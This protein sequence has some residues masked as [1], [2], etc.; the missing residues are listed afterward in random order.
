MTGIR[1]SL[2][3]SAQGMRPVDLRAEGSQRDR[4]KPQHATEGLSQLSNADGGLRVRMRQAGACGRLRDRSAPLPI[5]AWEAIFMIGAAV[6]GALLRP[7]LA[8]RP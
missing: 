7:A 6:K 8:G 4:R 3:I 2:P 1:Y 5:S